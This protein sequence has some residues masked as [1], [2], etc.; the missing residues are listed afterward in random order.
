MLECGEYYKFLQAT[1][2]CVRK[3]RVTRGQAHCGHSIHATVCS[4]VNLQ[5]KLVCHRI[6]YTLQSQY[7]Q[8]AVTE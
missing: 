4:I 2:E 7:P 1:K 3:E 5:Y 8:P 6:Q